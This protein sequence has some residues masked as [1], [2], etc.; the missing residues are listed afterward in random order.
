MLRVKQCFLF[1]LS[2]RL[3]IAGRY[4]PPL[5]VKFECLNG[6]FTWNYFFSLALVE[7]IVVDMGCGTGYG[8]EKLCETAT[9]VIGIDVS[10]RALRKATRRKSKKLNFVLADCQYPPI[11]P[12]CIDSLLSF[13]IIE[14]LRKPKIFLNNIKAIVKGKGVFILSTPIHRFPAPFNPFHIK[15]FTTKELIRLYSEIFGMIPQIFGKEIVDKNYLTHE[16][17]FLG[18]LLFKLRTKQVGNV[19][20]TIIARVMFRYHFQISSFKLSKNLN[21]ANTQLLVLKL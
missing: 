8:T 11:K 9:F 20:S 15:E 21:R 18:R 3:G 7:G 12:N 13:E 6:I 10:R 14:H 16:K 19:L 2:E 17:S 1:L 4:S 5:N